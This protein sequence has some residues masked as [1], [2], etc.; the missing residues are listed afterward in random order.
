MID[1]EEMGSLNEYDQ[2]HHDNDDQAFL[3]K[4][5]KRKDTNRI[6]NSHIKILDTR[7]TTPGLRLFEKYAVTQGGGFNHRLNLEQGIMI[8]DNH[9]ACSTNL[10]NTISAIEVCLYGRRGYSNVLF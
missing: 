5:H 4:D 10:S 7:K 2:P 1:D 6:K 8:K 3:T 9:L